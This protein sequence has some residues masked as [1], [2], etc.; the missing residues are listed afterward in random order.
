MINL[1]QGASTTH[2]GI[3]Q[4]QS[5]VRWEKEPRKIAIFRALYLGDLLLAV[6]ALRSIRARFPRAE[7]TLIGL[8]WA[9]AF[10]RRFSGYID[11]FVEFG[12]Y[13]GIDE[14]E[15]EPWRTRNF[16]AVQRAYGYDL[17]IQMHGSG[18]TSNACALAL[19][20]RVT[21]GY[22]QDRPMKG[23]TLG[24][25]YPKDVPEVMRNL[26]LA[27]LL[28]CQELDPRLEFPLLPAD[29]IE[30][31][32][33][34]RKLPRASH[35]WIGLHV[36]S[37]APARR[38]PAAYFA[39]VADYFVQHF[40]AQII[41][42]GSHNEE[43]TVQTVAKH[44]QARPYIVVGQTSTGGLAALI[45]ELDLYISND[46]GPAHIADAVDTPSVTIFGPVDPQRWAA[47]DRARHPIVRR[48][49]PCSPCSH[50]VCPID[51]RC[52]RWISPD[53]VINVGQELLMK[54]V[55]A[56]SA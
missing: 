41:L 29:R 11:R 45:S 52:L 5:I 23:L 37:K 46:T 27:Q 26:G 53:E 18:R 42:T 30:A 9:A 4:A 55:V 16:L 38:W 32:T 20:G 40:N 21:A 56:C 1:P 34:L 36:G 2:E 50:W 6:P 25:P 13:P 47:L 14:T 51:H 49:V 43:A 39:C 24:L 10:A 8:P 35:P 19:A 7:I 54:G 12:G 33:L 48:N 22:Y 28:G 15:V 3:W 44:M 17:V 31:A